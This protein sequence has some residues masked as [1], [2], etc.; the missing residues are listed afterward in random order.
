MKEIIMIE[1]NRLKKELIS[2]AEFRNFKNCVENFDLDVTKINE[3]EE[4]IYSS[5]YKEAVFRE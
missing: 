3:L 2:E 5:I 1:E 4:K